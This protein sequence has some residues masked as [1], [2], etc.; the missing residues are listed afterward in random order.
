[1]ACQRAC[2]AIVFLRRKEEPCWEAPEREL[3]LAI[4]PRF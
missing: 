4:K 3:S 2:A 1:M